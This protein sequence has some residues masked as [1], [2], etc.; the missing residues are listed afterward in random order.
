MTQKTARHI[1]TPEQIRDQQKR[2]AEKEL[3]ERQAALP[4][5]PV[6]PTSVAVPDSRKEVQKYLDDIAPA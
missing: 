2:Q 3:T 1:P 5:V 6:K 4:P